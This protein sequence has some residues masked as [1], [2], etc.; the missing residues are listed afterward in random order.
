MKNKKPAPD[1][2]L[3]AAEKLGARAEECV[4]VEDAVNGIQAAHAAKM[5]CVAVA[6]TFPVEVLR[7]ADIVKECIADIVLSDLV[8]HLMED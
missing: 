5:R 7:E 3:S 6:H 8:P 1:I 4:V 2:F